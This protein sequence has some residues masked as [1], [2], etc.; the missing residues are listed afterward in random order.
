MADDA[1]KSI[2]FNSLALAAHHN[3]P[4][5][6]TES[7]YY[8]L[9]CGDPIPERRRLAAPGCEYCIECAQELHREGRR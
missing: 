1:D 6:G 9:E 5:T 4:G 3:A 8:C 2:D 7:R